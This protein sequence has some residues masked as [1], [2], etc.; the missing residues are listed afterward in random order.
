MQERLD[1][2]DWATYEPYL[3]ANEAALRPR[4][5]ILFGPITRLARSD[6]TSSAS[7]PP[8]LGR[9]APAGE[10][11]VMAA[12]PQASRFAYLPI[13]TPSLGGAGARRPGASPAGTP[14]F[15]GAHMITYMHRTPSSHL[16]LSSI[17]VSTR[18]TMGVFLAPKCKERR[19]LK[20]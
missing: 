18:Y 12:A 15:A 17:T 7:A 5:A 8:A 14:T 16:S 1:P 3:W 20:S 9:G 13:S 6:G 11:N 2:I 10:A 19:G 4:T